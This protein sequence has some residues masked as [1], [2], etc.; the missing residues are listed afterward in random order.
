MVV[1]SD[2]IYGRKPV[3]RIVRELMAREEADG[4]LRNQRFPIL[5]ALRKA[6]ILKQLEGAYTAQHRINRT[7]AV[8]DPRP[9]IQLVLAN[10]GSTSNQWRPVVEQLVKMSRREDNPLVAVI[11]M[12]ISN[13]QTEQA[14]MELSSHRIPMV[15]AIIT[16]DGLEHSN[17][18]G[19]I[20]VSPSNRDYAEI[21]GRH[22]YNETNL[23]SAILVYDT[24]SDSDSN[25]DLFTKT[26]REAL[27]E[28]SDN[29]KEN[30]DGTRNVG[31]LISF[32][33]HAFT[34]GGLGKNADASQFAN[35]VSNICAVANPSAEGGLDVILYAGRRN[36]LPG[37][38]DAL[39]NRVCSGTP[40]TVAAAGIDPT[41]DLSKREDEL[42]KAKITFVS[43]ARTDDKGWNAE[44]PG[45]PERYQDFRQAFTELGFTPGHL[46]D[47]RV[48]M[49][50]DALLTAAKAVRLAASGASSP[51]RPTASDVH[52][53][54]MNLNVCYTVP[55]ASGT[56]SFS[57]REPGAGDPQNKPMLV[58]RFPGS[59]PGFPDQ[60][61]P[62]YYT[63]YAAGPAEKCST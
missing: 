19:L 61:G 24:N 20:R 3:I 34:G 28:K 29:A 40:M 41:A 10:E 7:G 60:V 46:V 27:T 58:V 39:Q 17:I 49:M 51:G 43:L 5:G 54:L 15:G 12:G 23:R 1:S 30:G 44:K 16:A 48:V 33:P 32:T 21:L 56:L 50:H 53:Q 57:Y 42:N 26:L 22:L 62:V 18:N 59:T 45:T 4:S 31:D 13:C 14:A 2:Q 52:G 47:D 63:P 36:D 37:F 38:L 6:E 8:G 35:I 11:G 55:A 9:P 25:C